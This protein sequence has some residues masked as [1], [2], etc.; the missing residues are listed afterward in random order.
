MHPLKHIKTN[1]RREREREVCSITRKSKNE[2]HFLRNVNSWS[3]LTPLLPSCVSSAKRLQISCRMLNP[4]GS[5]SI[6][7]HL[8]NICS[9]TVA[10]QRG[11]FTV[12]RLESQNDWLIEGTGFM[13]S[14][15]QYASDL[16]V[17]AT[18]EMEIKVW[19]SIVGKDGDLWLKWE[20]QPWSRI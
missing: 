5:F 15:G 4:E 19:P 16:E 7:W 3:L 14:I 17:G 12:G 18:C 9:L 13:W 6:I 20:P 1:T 10:R 2:K 11:L 8:F